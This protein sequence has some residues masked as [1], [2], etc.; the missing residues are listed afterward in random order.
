MPER[1]IVSAKRFSRPLDGAC[2]TLLASLDARCSWGSEESM[3]W[4]TIRGLVRSA[5]GT[6]QAATI[7]LSNDRLRSHGRLFPAEAA[8]QARSLL[9]CLGNIMALC[10]DRKKHT[11]LYLRDAYR[12][13]RRAVIAAREASWAIEPGVQDQ[14]RDEVKRLNRVAEILQLTRE[15]RDEL[16]GLQSWPGYGG[17]LS[18][19]NGLLTGT[20][21]AVLQ[22]LDQAWYG[23]QS[24]IA[25]QKDL[26]VG[27]AALAVRLERGTKEEWA[28]I[29]TDILVSVYLFYVCALSEVEAVGSWSRGSKKDLEAAWMV[30]GKYSA[31]A[32]DVCAARY[33]ELLSDR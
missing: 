22:A 6:Y 27:W 20:A 26:A 19:K 12:E 17:L 30:L 33:K 11:T 28:D 21:R 1:P 9:E 8:V 25:H 14:I 2:V 5:R 16:K 3:F 23:H 31:Q 18:A 32:R 29:R 4:W 13:G 15:E 7:L 24:R 10:V